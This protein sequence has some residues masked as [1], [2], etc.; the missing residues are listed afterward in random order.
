MIY[1]DGL[2]QGAP[3]ASSSFQPVDA[4]QKPPA[5]SSA[6]M[7]TTRKVR[8]LTQAMAIVLAGTTDRT[9]LT[10]LIGRRAMA[11]LIA[12]QMNLW[13]ALHTNANPAVRA[14]IIAEMVTVLSRRQ[15]IPSPGPFTLFAP[16]P[17]R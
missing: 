2:G 9:E 12:L 10:R 13:N 3:P 8:N 16:Q 14:P 4:T 6:G 11:R 1:S 17:R 7:E 5:G 15:I